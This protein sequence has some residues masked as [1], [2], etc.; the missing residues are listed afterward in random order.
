MT[1]PNDN[2]RPTMVDR[3]ET[4]TMTWVAGALAVIA[5]LGALFYF[6]SNGTDT[7][8]S[9]TPGTTTGSSTSVP[10]RPAPATPPAST[11]SK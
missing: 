6:M 10:A 3:N 2:G 8:A 9:T 7:T 4:N 5:V 11:P 1:N